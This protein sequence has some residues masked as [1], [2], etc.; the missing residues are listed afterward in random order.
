[1]YGKTHSIEAR[2]LISKPGVLNPMFGKELCSLTSFPVPF[3]K[4]KK[5]AWGKAMPSFS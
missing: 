1:M 5:E 3:F 2:M 4:K